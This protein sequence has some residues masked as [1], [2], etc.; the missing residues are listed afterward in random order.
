METNVW[1]KQY[2]IFRAYIKLVLTPHIY[3]MYIMVFMAFNMALQGAPSI[4]LI[5]NYSWPVQSCLRN[6]HGKLRNKLYE[7][8]KTGN[9]RF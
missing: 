1:K 3:S 9:S 7:L 8:F 5:P 2:T 6:L 4:L